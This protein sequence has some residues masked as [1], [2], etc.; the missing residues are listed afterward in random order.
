[1]GEHSSAES[2]SNQ[3]ARVKI[4]PRDG[5][6]YAHLIRYYLYISDAK[7]DMLFAQIPMKARER[8][9]AEFKFDLKVVSVSLRQ[10]PSE[11]S[12]YSK[13]DVVERYIRE[14][15]S[16]GTVDRPQTWFAGQLAMTAVSL[17]R[18]YL[19]QSTVVYFSGQTDQTVVGL[20]G[21]AHHLIGAQARVDADFAFPSSAVV[22]LVEVL[23]AQEDE[24][25]RDPDA[26]RRA[27]AREG[28]WPWLMKELM[29]KQTGIP[30]EI[31]FLA[32]RLMYAPPGLQNESAAVL[33][34]PIYV[35]A[36]D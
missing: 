34:S 19:Q 25:N 21:S 30:Q 13:L 28:Q 7:L 12:R 1:V 29:R 6:R 23:V 24:A 27:E 35:A 4:S 36:A 8:L 5:A 26:E 17:G 33:G 15:E 11:E 2:A 9:V 14:E 31:E 16:V 32:K 20:G 18:P 10:N 22:G 3:A